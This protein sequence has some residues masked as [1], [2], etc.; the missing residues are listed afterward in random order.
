MRGIVV[1]PEIEILGN[2]G[3]TIKSSNISPKHLRQYLLYWDKID[4]PMSNI[5]HFGDSPETSYLKEVG[6]LKRSFVK[7]QSSGELTDLFL[8]SQ[9]KAFN[10]NNKLEPGSWSIAQP[11]RRLILDEKS[12]FLKE[13]LEVELYS[14]LPVPTNDVSL[15]DILK[16]KERRK[17]EL[18]EFRILMD[19]LYLETTDSSN[20]ERMRVK[21]I[22]LLQHKIVELDRLMNESQISRFLGSLK[23]EVDLTQTLKNTLGGMV[24]GK[25]FGFPLALSG[26]IGF[27]SSFIKL[28]S[29]ITLKPKEI[30]ENLKD[31]AYLYYVNK[32]FI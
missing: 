16:F 26:A 19:K 21:N 13:N 24:A 12:C 31:F 3:M 28:N 6:F 23:I 32:D 14:C 5:I 15:D 20:L 7:I 25:T 2:R 10:Q 30:P 9:L 27:A 17:D 1:T 8:K 4:F 29:E 22:E 18:L 11:N